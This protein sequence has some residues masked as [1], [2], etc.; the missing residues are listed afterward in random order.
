MDKAYA[1]ADVMISRSG[2]M[3]V[4]EIC[5][6]KIPAVFVPYPFA[7]ED[8][9]TA[10]AMQ[11]VNKAAA[12][13][14]RDNEAKSKLV[15]TTLDLVKNENLQLLMKKHLATMAIS[16]ADEIVASEIL[17]IIDLDGSIAKS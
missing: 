14:V 4:A 5:V 17:K 12:L 16:N 1:A 10:N 3:S 15:R 13:I 11:L 2:A 8:H 7:A 6:V 9:Q